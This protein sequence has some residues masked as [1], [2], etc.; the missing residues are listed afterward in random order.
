MGERPKGM[1]W[2]TYLRLLTQLNDHGMAAL[3]STDKLVTQLNS[4]MGRR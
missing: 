4:R 1:H 2:K 3:Q